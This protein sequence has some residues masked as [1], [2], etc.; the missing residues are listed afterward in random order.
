MK[1]VFFL[2]LIIGMSSFSL[3]A[4]ITRIRPGQPTGQQTTTT[5]SASFSVNFE[6]IV[7]SYRTNFHSI[8][9]ELIPSENEK[10]VF[11]ST[12]TLPGTLHAMIYRFHS[13]QD[14]SASWQ[15]MLYSGTEYKS[16]M[17]H[18]KSLC[19]QINKMRI[20]GVGIFKGDYDEPDPNLR[21]AGT[22]YKL[23]TEDKVYKNFF[24]EVDMVM[25]S[26]EEWEVHLSLVR[27]REDQD[28]Y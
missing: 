10:L 21:F 28:M 9:G 18:Y 16:A 11:H 2:A 4:Q 23:E 6:K 1:P 20:G 27:K 25:N 24:A 7:Q 13:K 12:M 19:K 8:Q 5:G 22:S 17:K 14:T 15:A 26:D 3:E